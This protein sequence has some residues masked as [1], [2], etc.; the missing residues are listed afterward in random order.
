MIDASGMFI[1]EGVEYMEACWLEQHGESKKTLKFEKKSETVFLMKESVV[2]PF[3]NYSIGK[4]E[5]ELLIDKLDY[6]DVL[7]YIDATGMSSI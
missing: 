7:T 6:Y 3:V 2:Y 4:K 5:N 1:A